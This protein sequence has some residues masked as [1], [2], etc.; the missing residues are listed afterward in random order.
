MKEAGICPKCGC[1]DIEYGTVDFG[2]DGGSIFYPVTCNNCGH[3][4]KEWY[5]LI[6]IPEVEQ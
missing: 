6:F 1:E 5:D 4:D 2:T 3:Q